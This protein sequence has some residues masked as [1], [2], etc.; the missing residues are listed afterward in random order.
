MKPSV[1]HQETTEYQFISFCK[2]VLRNE[3]RN[4][5]AEEKRWNDKFVSLDE[6]AEDYVEALYVCDRYE[7]ETFIFHTHSYS[8]SIDDATIAEAV[9]H[10]PERQKDIILLS[11]FLEM[12]DVEVAA[13]MG[14]TTSTLHYQKTKA[15]K[16]L[17]KFMKEARMT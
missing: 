9:T 13:L 5:R 3:V 6:L 16:A 8:I 1:T 15:L 11:V 12:K 14:L 17:R 10:L 7:V 2:A 4:I